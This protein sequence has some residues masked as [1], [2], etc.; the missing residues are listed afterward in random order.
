MSEGL[1]DWAVRAWAEPG[2]GEAGLELQ[3]TAGQNVPLLL[4]AAWA[5]RTGRRLDAEALEAG[6]DVAR[7]WDE[8]AVAALRSVRRALKVRQPDLDDSDREAVRA[9]VRAVELDAE[10]R[11]LLALEALAPAPGGAARPVLE[12]LVAVARQWSPVTPRA[13]LTRLAESLPA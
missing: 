8:A 4:W 12:A 11:L 9:Q 10:R 5:A 13:G 1:W 3:D 6:C 2:V 7:A